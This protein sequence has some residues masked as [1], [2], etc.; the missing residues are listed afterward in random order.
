MRVIKTPVVINAW[1]ASNLI[2][3]I[4]A[5]PE[6]LQPE[7]KVPLANG[8]IKLTAGVLSV[9]LTS[10]TIIPKPTDWILLDSIGVFHRY[11]QASFDKYYSEFIE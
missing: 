1:L 7:L 11:T 5:T 6:T 8:A 10:T 4:Q 9:N 3:L 2:I